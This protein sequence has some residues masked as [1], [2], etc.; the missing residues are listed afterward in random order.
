M[1]APEFTDEELMAYADGELAEDR[2][3]ALDL[4]LAVDDALAERLG[5]FTD[6]R[7][8]AADALR[9]LLDAPV[10]AHLV[11]RVRDLAAAEAARALPDDDQV[12]N[13]N[14]VA[15]PTPSRTRSV[16]QMPIAASIV[17]AIGVGAGLM[18]RNSGAPATGLEIAA[19]T[20]PAITGAL[21]T[22]ASGESLPLADGGRIGAIATFRAEDDALCRE[23][24]FDRGNGTAFVSIACHDGQ[25]WQI[26]LAI[27]AA[28]ADETGYAPASSIE[29]LDAYL[30][31]TN[32][33]A[34]LPPADEAA[35]LAKLP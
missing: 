34:P 6:T 4:A 5:L 17:F 21:A 19:V 27:A 14:V 31:A 7:M 29:A 20:D 24:E 1:N 8:I 15:F 33:G 9:P 23:F 25:D 13:N 12:Q 26:R 18:L 35:S 30:S 2:A 3:A 32:A 16:W 22:L 11:Q 28:V 10:P